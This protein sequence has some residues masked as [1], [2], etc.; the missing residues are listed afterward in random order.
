M[1]RGNVTGWTKSSAQGS[2]CRH[3]SRGS[4]T[5]SRSSLRRSDG[6]SR[7]GISSSAFSTGPGSTRYPRPN[8]LRGYSPGWSTTSSILVTRSSPR[9]LGTR[10]SIPPYAWGRVSG[11][12]SNGSGRPMWMR[13]VLSQVIRRGPNTAM[14]F[15]TSPIAA[16]T[17]I[18]VVRLPPGGVAS[19]S[20]TKSTYG[21]SRQKSQPGSTFGTRSNLRK[22]F[23]SGSAP[24]GESGPLFARGSKP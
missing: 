16:R 24:T 2:G 6:S 20:T 18:L 10:G 12:D 1:Y 14:C 8:G 3:Q 5:T 19:P 21:F 9:S 4:R 7:F 22:S 23:L 11:M 17:S 13:S 15:S